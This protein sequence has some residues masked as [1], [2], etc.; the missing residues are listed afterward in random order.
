MRTGDR[1]GADALDDARCRKED[2]L[3][4]QTFHQSRGQHDPF[5]GLPCQF[6]E[7]VYAG[8]I[9]PRTENQGIAI[10]ENNS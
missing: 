3:A 8:A 4:A 5:V 1:L 7:A 10:L 9:V 6:I 2:A